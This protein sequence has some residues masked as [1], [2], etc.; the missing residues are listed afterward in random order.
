MV[1]FNLNQLPDVSPHLGGRSQRENQGHAR[2][3]RLRILIHRMEN[4]IQDGFPT[5]YLQCFKV[6]AVNLAGLNPASVEGLTRK[7]PLPWYYR[8]RDMPSSSILQS[9]KSRIVVFILKFALIEGKNEIVSKR[10]KKKKKTWQKF[11]GSAASRFKASWA[12]YV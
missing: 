9:F 6:K 2:G 8:W 1:V 3:Q 5:S 4:F 12:F 7:F 11:V 10:E